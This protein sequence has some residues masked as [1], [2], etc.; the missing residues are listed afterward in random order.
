VGAFTLQAVGNAPLKTITGF[1]I[2]TNKPVVTSFGVPVLGDSAV[3]ASP[4]STVVL[5]AMNVDPLP[6]ATVLANRV[7]KLMGISDTAISNFDVLRTDPITGIQST[8]S[9]TALAAAEVFAADQKIMAFSNA[10]STVGTYLAGVLNASAISS[11]ATAGVT[12]TG[13]TISTAEVA[14]LVSDAF[15]NVLARKVSTSLD[16]TTSNSFQLRDKFVTLQDF[17]PSSG[18]WSNSKMPIT[19]TSGVAQI[20]LSP[21]ALNYQNMSNSLA[22]SGSFNAPVLK[23]ALANVPTTPNAQITVSATLTDGT[24]GV[25]NAGER[26]ASL[27]VNLNWTSNGSSADFTMPVQTLRA[28]YQDTRGNNYTFEFISPNGAKKTEIYKR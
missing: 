19:V 15:F 9:A 4:I 16:Q 6:T 18:I 21:S 14:K 8:T 12:V 17:D 7:S 28:T 23:F 13:E 26:Q 11:A 10:A 2:G 25:R 3:V 20:D 1:D 24:N 5:N 27:T 22:K